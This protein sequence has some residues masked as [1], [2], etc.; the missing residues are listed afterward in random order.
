MSPRAH[1][2]EIKARCPDLESV[3]CSARELCGSS[4]A[5]ELQTDTY[6]EVAHGRLKLREI[7]KKPPVLIAYHRPDT[8][9][10]RTSGYHLVPVADAT[11]LKAALSD[12]LSVR[13]VV[14]K[15]RE[16]YLWHNVRIHLDEVEGLGNF[17]ELEA[18]VT[19]QDD[20]KVCRSRVEFLCAKLQIR[21][22]AQMGP[23]YAD[24]L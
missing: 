14:R 19:P 16:I 1:N 7:E 4:G 9:G 18:V 23:S 20:E 3:R 22:E 11:L 17:I 2:L 24:L 8:P 10:A 6:F 21:S 15:R 12:A 5:I 13:V